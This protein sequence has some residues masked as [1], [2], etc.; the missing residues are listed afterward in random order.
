MTMF[1]IGSPTPPLLKLVGERAVAAS[2]K[3]HPRVA[4]SMT[5]MLGHPH[6]AGYLARTMEAMFPRGTVER[7]TVHGEPDAM[8]KKDAHAIVERADIVFVPGGDPVAGAKMLVSAGAAEWLREARARGAILV[9]ISAGSIALGAWWGEW[10]A[11]GDDSKAELVRC[12]NVAE[13]FVFDAHA[14]EDDWIELRIVARLLHRR[15]RNLRY[16]GLPTGA[17]IEVDS[18]GN[19]HP[20]GVEPFLLSEP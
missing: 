19:I 4:V 2:K 18:T 6:G 17:A 11:D 3:P 1:L 10:P 20:I 7:F 5:T 16:V 12:T 8:P 15:H 13:S 14:E 9:G